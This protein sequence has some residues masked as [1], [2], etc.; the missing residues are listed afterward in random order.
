[1]R[2]G[3]QN[4]LKGGCREMSQ[5]QSHNSG[6]PVWL[7]NRRKKINMFLKIFTVWD[8]FFIPRA[9][10][11]KQTTTHEDNYSCI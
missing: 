6:A 5:Q 3:I 2:M 1:M 7:V 11:K 4:I 8:D 10:K 9:L